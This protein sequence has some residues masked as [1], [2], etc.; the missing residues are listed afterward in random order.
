[1]WQIA[2]GRMTIG[3]SADIVAALRRARQ[4]GGQYTKAM[5][6]FAVFALAF[7]ALLSA[8]TPCS[9]SVRYSPC[10]LTFD[11]S[12]QERQQHPNPYRTVNMWAEFRSPD[13]KTYKM[14]AFWDGQR[15]VI[16]FS[17][18]EV[19]EWTYRVTSN[20]ESMNGKIDKFTAGTADV[21]G[22]IRPANVHHWIYSENRRPHLWISET[23]YLFGSAD[24][25]FFDQMLAKRAEQK[26]THIRGLILPPQAQ[27]KKAFPAPDQPDATYFKQLD[28]R[29]AA[30]HAKGLVTDLILGGPADQLRRM[31]PDREALNRYISYVAARYSSFNIT[32]ELVLDYETYTDARAFVKE[33][34]T[35]LKNTDPYNHPRTT[36]TQS[37]S[38]PL[39]DDAWMNY[40]SYHTGADALG[41]VEHELYPLPQVNGEF[42]EEGAAGMDDAAFRA[43][44]WNT[45]MSGQWVAYNHVGTNGKAQ[46]PNAAALDAPGAKA[47]SVLADVLQ[48]T[49]YWELEPHYD[50]DNSRTL[51]MAGTDYLVYIE[52]P[53]PFQV[54]VEK[55]GY[56]VYWINPATGEVRKDKD[57]K[58]SMTK[59][60]K[61]KKKKQEKDNPRDNLHMIDEDEAAEMVLYSGQTPDNSHDWILHLSRD[62]RKEGM[63][64]S[65][66]FNEI[67]I[68]LQ[69]PEANI[70]KMPFEIAEPKSEVNLVAGQP[71]HYQ[72]TLKKQTPGTR[73]MTYVLKGSVVDGSSTFFFLNTGDQGTFTVP[74][75][76][77]RNDSM[78]FMLRVYALN[79]PGKLYITDSVYTVN[80]P[81]AQQ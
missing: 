11:L 50:G 48:S 76:L 34:G 45:V 58:F 69:E 55:H 10:E 38:S 80:K 74:P 72:I 15:M 27:E 25:S 2:S 19:G 26:F 22:F 28:Q 17:P 65:V 68:R 18:T 62:G 44:L 36:Q 13:Y 7:P 37:T 61:E 39:L 63:L 71:V 20:V 49:R 59:E 5:R 79:A 32:W 31:F 40:L 24:Q 46:T 77:V 51:A 21:P 57:W 54:S 75:S 66:K 67:T 30:I 52:K 53:G 43:R 3:R 4:E 35:N 78:S 73:R 60:E 1:M 33:I 42:A 9:S 64:K 81:G 14:P 6:W 70:T 23:S 29:V 12:A 16:R 8:Q 41:A 56:N 47:M